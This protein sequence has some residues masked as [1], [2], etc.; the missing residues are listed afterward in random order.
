MK[1]LVI[2]AGKGDRLVGKGDSKPLVSLLGLPLIARV[3]LTCRK[4][5]IDDFY[6]VTGYNSEKLEDFLARLSDDRNINITC[7]YNDEWEQENGLSVLKAKGLLN[8]NFILNMSDHIIEADII[9][10]LMHEPIED[11]E[12][13]LAVDYNIDSNSLVDA[14][15]VTKVLINDE[16]ITGIG[17]NITEYNAYD[18]GIFLCT[19]AIFS[20]IERNIAENTDTTLSGGIR[21]LA[22]DKKAK[23]F[24]IQ[25]GFWIDVDDE[26]ALLKAEKCLMERLIKLT[27]GPV[28]RFIN[29]P[30]SAKI[31]KYFLKIDIT[32]N[33]IAFLS[34]IL[35]LLSAA[36]FSFGN[37]IALAVRAILTQLSSI[38]DGCDGEIARLRFKE[39][40]YGKWFDAVL[41]RYADAFLLFGLTIYVHKTGGELPTLIIGFLAIIGSFMN[42]YTA[43]KYDSL[44][45]RTLAP[46]KMRF[47]IGRDIRMFIIF[48][49]ALLNQ[50]FGV[51]VIIALMMNLENIR[52]IFVCYKKRE[53]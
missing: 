29:R 42:S 10:R 13:V 37:Y 26:K 32:P 28:S 27:D 49:G 20:A 24:D 36:L 47:R 14:D 43:D 30:V 35:S 21:T 12:V 15:D 34:F 50:A 5:G 44:M 31:T 51:L 23:G 16:Y 17:K 53:L 3:I 48:I 33:Q 18:T 1:C 25:D 45:E 11:D 6:V 9:K 7:I 40:D 52:R 8:E 39:S 41:D 38:V 19:P 22:A 2:A 46:K 4:A